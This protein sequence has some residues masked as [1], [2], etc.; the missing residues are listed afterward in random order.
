MN[1]E[2]QGCIVTLRVGTAEADVSL[3]VHTH[4]WR[5]SIVDVIYSFDQVFG[6]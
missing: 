3:E 6:V 4:F 2:W 1:C 5:V